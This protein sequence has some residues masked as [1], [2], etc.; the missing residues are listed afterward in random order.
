M[1]LLILPAPL[2]SLRASCTVRLYSSFYIL[3]ISPIFLHHA[4]HYLPHLRALPGAA[5]ARWRI[6]SPMLLLRFGRAHKTTRLAAETAT[7]V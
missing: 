1:S 2:L 7:R 4:E 6:L 3:D 5:L